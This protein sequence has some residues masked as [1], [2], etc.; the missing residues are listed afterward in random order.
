[1]GAMFS[2]SRPKLDDFMS[3]PINSTA[4]VEATSAT[5]YAMAG[6]TL[7]K[8]F[9]LPVVVPVLLAF[10]FVAVWLGI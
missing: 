2:Y 3:N 4:A 9:I 5:L 7:C 6:F 1:M 10:P 8:D